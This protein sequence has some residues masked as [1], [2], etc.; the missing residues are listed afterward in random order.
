[1][2]ALDKLNAKERGPAI[3][4]RG[5]LNRLGEL[6]DRI[7]ADVVAELIK[8]LDETRQHEGMIYFIGNG[9]KA[10][11]AS[12]FANDLG[13]ETRM[14][15]RAVSLTDNMPAISGI[16][17]DEGY[18]RIFTRQLD[19]LLVG[20]GD[21]LVAMSASATSPNV[22]RGVEYALSEGAAVVAITGQQGGALRSL[23]DLEIN[24]PSEADECGLVEDACMAIMHAIVNYFMKANA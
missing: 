22:V 17:N 11:V 16:A 7:D 6:L 18:E 15:F 9:G 19:A 3:F 8:L 24:V 21:V 20:P 5:Y 10:A 14:R 23:V 2:T 12:E 13:I 4:V 1:M